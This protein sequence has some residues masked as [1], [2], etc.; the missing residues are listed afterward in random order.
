MTA[1][2]LRL[3]TMGLF[4]FA[5]ASSYPTGA[6]EPQPSK[7]TPTFGSLRAPSLETVRG[8]AAE[9]LKGTGKF[10]Q[11][12]FDAIWKQTDRPLLDLVADTFALGSPD[13]KKLLEEARDANAP[14]PAQVPDLVKDTKLPAFFRANL[15]LAY[16]QALTN[17]RVYEEALEVLKTLKAEQVIDPAA[18]YFHRAVTEHGTLQ[19]NDATKSIGRLLDD[20]P[21]APERYKMVAAL[22]FLDMQQW[23]A[24]DLGDISRQM[25][26]IE[27]RLDL[28][29]GGPKTQKL[30]KDVV[31][32]LDE[33][34]K[35]LENQQKGQGQGQGQGD[36]QQPGCPPGGQPGQGQG[37]QP[38][39]SAGAPTAPQQDS[40]GGQNS[41]PGNVDPKKLREVVESWGKLPEKERAKAMTEMVRSMPPAYRQMIED[42][43]RKSAGGTDGR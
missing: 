17:R 40:F 12:A 35:K 7:A 15:A 27:R 24:K 26:N 8:Q 20:V 36:G 33:L 38:G 42:Y 41:G 18:F 39:Q 5:L 28:A 34:I 16:A 29:R 23:K 4:A 22:M 11:A 14:P 1:R 9:W 2:Y 10:D 32:R 13:A 43:Y 21:D 3:A 6:A 37:S 31:A 25:N 30:Q 19:K